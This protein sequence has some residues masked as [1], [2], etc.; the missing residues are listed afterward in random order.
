MND[1]SDG[2]LLQLRMT[3]PKRIQYVTYIYINKHKY[4]SYRLWQPH[5]SVEQ[6]LSWEA[7]KQ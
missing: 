5:N 4:F 2:H 3:I 6:S 1:N 7:N